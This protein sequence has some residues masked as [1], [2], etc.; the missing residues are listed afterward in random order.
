MSRR[1]VFAGIASGVI[2]LASCSG[3]GGEPSGASEPATTDDRAP[4]SVAPEVDP[5]AADEFAVEPE[6]TIDVEAEPKPGREPLEITFVGDVMF[7]RW[8]DTGLDPILYEEHDVL[9]RVHDFLAADLTV[10]N[11]ETPLV[12][13]L[14]EQSPYGTNLRFAASPRAAAYLVRSGIDV[15]SLA[16]NHS[17]DMRMTGLL[18]TPTIVREAGLIAIGVSRTE[19]PL[20]RVEPVEVA[21]WKIGF[22]AA[23]SERNG[24]QR[25][26]A[27]E[28]PY[29]TMPEMAKVLPPIIRKARPD[30]D[31]IIAFLHWGYEEKLVP[32]NWQVK[33]GRAMIDA[34]ADA[35]IGH[36]PHVL[37]PMEQ[38]GRGFIAYSLGNFL[39]DNTTANQ[40][41]TGVLR[42][43]FR[44]EGKCL[45]SAVV[46][47]VFVKG[48]PTQHPRPA[49]RWLRRKIH[50]RITDLS[51]EKP[52]RTEWRAE[53]RDLALVGP[54]CDKLASK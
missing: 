43:R 9:G 5:V 53:G 25:K 24:P 28:L 52:F 42:L 2:V 47:P 10:A 48:S 46:H 17:F 39:F 14:P 41:M 36:H 1:I 4:T 8:R 34:G 7:G 26:N 33:A 12:Y 3:R 19:P 51:R 27:P 45:E 18:Q 22:L 40:Q 38:Y 29:L 6:V 49:T 15:V 32:H 35:V 21:G 13:E 20:F 23:T 11:L 16:N 37:Q 50:K 30:Y 31:L 54:P 44:P